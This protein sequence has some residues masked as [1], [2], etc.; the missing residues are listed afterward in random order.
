V[1]LSNRRQHLS[2]RLT[3]GDTLVSE[4]GG[5]VSLA[6][7]AIGRGSAL[8]PV[9]P[10]APRSSGDRITYAHAGVG[11]WLANGPFGIE[12]V[13]TV[14]RRPAGDGALTL[15]LGG[16]LPTTTHLAFGGPT[17]FA[18]TLGGTGAVHTFLTPWALGVTRAG[19]GAGSVTGGPI[20]CPAVSCAGE[21]RVGRD[22]T[23]TATAAPG[24]K[25]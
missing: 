2:A 17:V 25:G 5:S 8:T 9:A 24:G 4:R 10:T 3:R 18:V 20:D 11:E 7:C 15:A 16:N 13:F 22:V 21:A 19:A 6:L 14:A 12:Q 1:T 23:L